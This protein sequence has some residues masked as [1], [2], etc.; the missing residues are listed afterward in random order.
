MTKTIHA[1]VSIPHRLN[2]N[3]KRQK[4]RYDLVNC[5]QH[6]LFYAS[7]EALSE[8][9]CVLEESGTIQITVH[10]TEKKEEGTTWGVD[11]NTIPKT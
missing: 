10:F 7:P 11:V 2:D 4:L 5:V 8:L 9:V 3:E 6:A 1:D